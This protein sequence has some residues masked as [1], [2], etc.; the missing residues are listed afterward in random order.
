MATIA[1]GDLAQAGAAAGA[2]SARYCRTQIT[3]VTA[4]SASVAPGLPEA[5][6]N[7]LDTRKL[8]MRSLR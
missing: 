8:R 6:V 7:P 4:A 2:G 1:D 3:R 5:S